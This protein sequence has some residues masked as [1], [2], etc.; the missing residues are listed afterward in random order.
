MVYTA[1]L[2]GVSG[3]MG[4]VP[5]GRGGGRGGGVLPRPPPRVITNPWWLSADVISLERRA[6]S[7]LD[8]LESP[9]YGTRPIGTRT[10]K[11]LTN[12]ESSHFI[13]LLLLTSLYE[14]TVHLHLKCSMNAPA[15]H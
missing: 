7:S 1:E 10:S 11:S 13:L 14:A 3:G 2:H 15:R 12:V 6:A 8:T 5:D 4:R 9:R